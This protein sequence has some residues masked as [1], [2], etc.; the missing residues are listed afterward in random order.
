MFASGFVVLLPSATAQARNLPEST[1]ADLSLSGS[2]SA[3]VTI[4]ALRQSLSS[5][6][7]SSDNLKSLNTVLTENN[8]PKDETGFKRLFDTYSDIIPYK[9]RF[10][11]QNAFLVYYTKGFDGFG[12]S[13]I[14]SDLPVKQTLQYGARNDAWLAWQEFLDELDY[15]TKH[16]QEENFDELKEL[17]SKTLLLIDAYVALAPEEDQIVARK[18]LQ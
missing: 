18:Q 13:T 5:V 11:D 2:V 3:L 9:Q 14:E 1:G 7:S 16:P 15:A 6:L 10:V 8:V 17:L 12:R 4:I